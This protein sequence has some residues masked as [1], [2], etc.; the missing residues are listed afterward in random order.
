MM[1]SEK[2]QALAD[3]RKLDA[4]V[5]VL[6]I[7]DSED[8]PSEVCRQ[9]LDSNER[10]MVALQSIAEECKRWRNTQP[11]SDG[12][13]NG[14]ALH[15]QIIAEAGLSPVSPALQSTEGKPK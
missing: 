4:V 9:L 15:L 5:H 11:A 13:S 14:W 8:I 1:A 2:L 6:G 3:Q 7:E 12:A 10:Q